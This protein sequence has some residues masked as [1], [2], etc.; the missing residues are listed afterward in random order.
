MNILL[1]MT[2]IHAAAPARRG[3]YLEE[4]LRIGKVTGAGNAALIEFTPEQ[5]N[6]IKA[7]FRVQSAKR[8]TL[9]SPLSTLH[10][11]DRVHQIAGPIGRAIHWPC[12]KGNGTTD[13]KPG[14]PC[15]KTKNFLNK[16]TL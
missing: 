14:S 15:D 12:M 5:F 3:G 1:P 7:R 16:I 4:C 13:L 10:L 11:G 9:H 8:R 6:Q 2:K